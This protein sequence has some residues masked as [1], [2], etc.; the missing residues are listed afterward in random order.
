M[1]RTATSFNQTRLSTCGLPCSPLLIRSLL[2]PISVGKLWIVRQINSI[3]N[4]IMMTIRVQATRTGHIVAWRPLM[5]GRLEVLSFPQRFTRLTTTLPDVLVD[6]METTRLHDP[7]TR[8]FCIVPNGPT[9]TQ[10]DLS[11]TGRDFQIVCSRRLVRGWFPLNPLAPEFGANYDIVLTA[12]GNA[13]LV[14]K[15]IQGLRTRYH[16][17]DIPNGEPIASEDFGLEPTPA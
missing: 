2:T 17:L 13:E 10:L 7:N 6:V 4:P 5:E 15:L 16:C 8:L 3:P 12:H 1:W 11:L 14:S 9:T